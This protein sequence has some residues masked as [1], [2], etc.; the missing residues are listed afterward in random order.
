MIKIPIISDIKD[1]ALNLKEKIRKFR[2]ITG[3]VILALSVLMVLIELLVLKDSL[4]NQAEQSQKLIIFAAVC[5]ALRLT[6]I[7]YAFCFLLL[8]ARVKNK[9][10]KHSLYG[11]LIL[12]KIIN[13]LTI[14]GWG[15]VN[16][17]IRGLLGLIPIT[18]SCYV[19]IA[20]VAFGKMTDY[21]KKYLDEL[22]NQIITN[23]GNNANEI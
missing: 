12:L 16:N 13:L 21:L 2:L 1:S 14:F 20:S 23:K 3:L 11:I 7:I 5:L 17:I 10:L 8:S 15:S 22:K 18:I 19:L 9:A 6:A 4:L